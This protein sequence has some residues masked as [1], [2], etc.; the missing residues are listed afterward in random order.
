MPK[1]R[2]VFPEL[3]KI[4]SEELCDRFIELNMD[5]YVDNQ[6]IERMEY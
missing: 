5:F 4:D 2:E 1:F 3:S 6:K